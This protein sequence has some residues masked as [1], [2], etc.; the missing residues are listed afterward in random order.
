[1]KID[2]RSKKTQ[3]TF[4]ID[5][6]LDDCLGPLLGAVKISKNTKL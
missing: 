5:A 3:Y 2:S 6:I 4:P 1:M